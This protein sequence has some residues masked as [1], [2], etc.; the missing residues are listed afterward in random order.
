MEGGDD[1]EVEQGVWP[2]NIWAARLF[3]WMGTQWRSGPAGLTGLDYNVLD[4]AHLRIETPPEL[5]ADA[6][7]GLQ[8]MEE[9][10]LTYFAEERSRG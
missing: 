1:L 3:L 6:E 10:A 8:V 7:F 2:E 4:R 9:E 5:Q